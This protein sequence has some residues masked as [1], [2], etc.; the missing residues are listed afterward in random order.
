MKEKLAPVLNREKESLRALCNEIYSHPELALEEFHACAVLKD[1]LRKQG[2][3]VQDN[4]GDLE[5]AFVGFCSSEGA[6]ENVPLLGFIAE[7]DALPGMGH[8]CGHN[9]IATSA[10]AASLA[11]REILE[12]KKIPYRLCCIGTPAEEGK[13]GKILMLQKGVFDGVSAILEAHPGHKTTPDVGELSVQRCTVKFHGKAAHAAICPEK[14]LNA[15]EAACDFV[16]AL[17]EWKKNLGKRER[18]H[19]I[20]TKGGEVPNIIP[21]YAEAFYYLR[22]PNE[23]YL[24]PMQERF[25]QIAEEAAAGNG[26]RCELVWG[27][28]SYKGMVFNHALNAELPGIW[29]DLTAEEIAMTTGTEGK[30]SSDTGNVSYL[31]PCAQYH[32]G[33]TGGKVVPLHTPEFCAEAG[34]EYAFE[35]SLKIGQAM[36][37]VAEKYFKDPSFRL[38]VRK[39]FEEELARSTGAE[40]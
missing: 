12:E 4:A 31:V 1:Y 28:N 17:K 5:T 25:T 20:L 40:K 22:A 24:L 9:L 34:T 18:I 14:G 23:K 15:L 13:G 38:Q 27:T 21:A 3:T 33:V 36:A 8:G 10:V 29:K 30:A 26:C 19:G 37:L 7:Y 16:C 2:F 35:Q 32:F 39:D 11:A 6:S